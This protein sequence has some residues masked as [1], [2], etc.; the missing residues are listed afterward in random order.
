M[1]EDETS[2]IQIIIIRAQSESAISTVLRE[3]GGFEG[4]HKMHIA[5][6]GDI[7]NVSG[8]AG[9]VG[10]SSKAEENAFIQIPGQSVKDIDPA[11]L[12]AQLGTMRVAMKQQSGP[13]PTAEQDDEIG[14]VA[15]A[16]IAAKNGDEEGILTHLKQVGTWTLQV[17]KETGAEIIALTLAHLLKG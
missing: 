13:T 2:G 1:E 4:N 16:Q 15:R 12:A 5:H 7:Y 17:A 6:Q 14:H 8:Q 11:A 3:L 10:P 9:A